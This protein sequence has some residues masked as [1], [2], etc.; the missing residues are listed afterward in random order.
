MFRGERVAGRRLLASIAMLNNRVAGTFSRNED[1]YQDPA[2][3]NWFTNRPRERA[4]SPSFPFSSPTD[5][6]PVRS[7]ALTLQTS[8]HPYPQPLSSSRHFLPSSDG[9]DE[10]TWIFDASS[11]NVSCLK[12]TISHEDQIKTKS[13]YLIAINLCMIPLS[14]DGIF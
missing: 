11:K 14:N 1:V 8:P 13:F 9:R 6:F 12:L 3:G 2:T 7:P 4:S 5:I 10:S